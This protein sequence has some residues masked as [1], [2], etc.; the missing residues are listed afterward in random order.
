MQKTKSIF[1]EWYLYKTAAIP[2]ITPLVQLKNKT[3][4][5]F[6]FLQ[7]KL[8]VC[9]CIVLVGLQL[10]SLGLQIVWSLDMGQSWSLESGG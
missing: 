8:T 5:L 7:N 6:Y 3:L 4:T 2:C 1:I 10:A 9:L